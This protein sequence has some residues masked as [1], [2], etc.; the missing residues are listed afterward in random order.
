MN[1]QI[2]SLFFRTLA[3]AALA[4][5]LTA[6]RRA[7]AQTFTLDAPLGVARWTHTA[8]ALPDGEVLI[9]GGRVANDFSTDQFENTSECEVYSPDTGN[10]SLTGYMSVA[11]AS[12]R[13]VLLRNGLVLI[14]G[15]EDNFFGDTAIAELFDEASGTWT[16]TGSLQE[17]RE[18]FAMVTLPNGCILV[19]GG[20][21]NGLGIDL[22]STEIYDPA[23]Q[24]W[25][26]AAPM[27][28]AADSQTATLLPNGLVLVT[29]GSYLGNTLTNAILYNPA[30]N[31]W[32]NTGGMN[33]P[34]ASH[35]AT[36][37]P[38]G[39]VLVVGSGNSAETYDPATG[40]WTLVAPMNTWRSYPSATLLPNGQVLALGGDPGQTSAELYNSSSNT[41]TLTGSLN[42]GRVF[43]TATLVADG[44][45]VVA[46]GDAGTIGYYNGPPMADVETY[47][48][49][50]QSNVFGA[51]LDPA[52]LAWTTTGDSNWVLESTNTYFSLDAAQSGSV[53]NDQS[54]TLTLDVTGPAVITFFWSSIANDTNGGFDLEFYMD[55]P[56]SGDMGDLTGDTSWTQAGPFTIPAGPHT[57]NWTVSAN[58]D[59]D[60][61]EA[62]FVDQV[63]CFALTTTNPATGPVGWWKG[64]ANALDSAGSN[65]GT[66]QGVVGF[67]P[68]VFGQA[69]DF[70]GSGGCVELPGV[71]YGMPEGT[72]SLWTYLRAWDWEFADNGLFVWAGTELLP[73]VGS[74]DGI[75]LGTHPAYTSTGE[76]LFGIFTSDWQW[77]HSGVVPKT[78][79]WYHLAGTWGPG[80]IKI[81]V[82]GQLKGTNAY[83][84]SAP[85]YSYY[86]L[87]GR[88]SWDSSQIT[89]LVDD[90]R[91]YNRALG[92]S[93]IS[94]LANP[95]ANPRLSI[96]PIGASVV[97]S[98]PIA[99][100]G[101]TLE[102]TPSL[103]NPDWE[104]V[105]SQV[106]WT[107][108]NLVI[109][110]AATGP[111]Q[112]FRLKQ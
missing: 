110:N 87:I 55:D 1:A 64:E 73:G 4:A 98:W 50:A 112:F 43:H 69:F 90:V 12:G 28:F 35:T 66:F 16:N 56:D 102:S 54:T 21:D 84:G 74:W 2:P 42:V 57:L 99:A 106:F 80:G 67:A 88:S 15:G 49:S 91:L 86:N 52:D 44:Q 19:V 9:A 7:A 71:T 85:N 38:N 36:L 26:N 20:Y 105:T 100:S 37:L 47:N 17:E 45:V 77:A 46:G 6:P 48:Q 82:D 5:N 18:A 61:T 33:A 76:L 108:T 3:L 32:S 89:G 34:R 13:A 103:S 104:P 65:N 111:A 41:W 70:N 63:D 22:P 14:A 40:V 27:G 93:E 96:L 60:P 95:S 83:T 23:T 10:S 81:Y 109:T 11:H 68:G 62:G 25:T 101:F 30:N 107:S 72:I 78:N 24:V 53:T 97:I 92:A 94:T 75:N 59:T 39:Q 58:G 51:V 31:T 8:T 29:G 79:T